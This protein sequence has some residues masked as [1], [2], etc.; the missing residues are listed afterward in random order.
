MHSVGKR[1]KFIARVDRNGRQRWA[2]KIIS[3]KGNEKQ[4]RTTGQRQEQRNGQV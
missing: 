4:H 1:K 3:G 2:L